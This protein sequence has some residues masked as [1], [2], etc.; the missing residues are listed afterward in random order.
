M[1]PGDPQQLLT[2]LFKED[3]R[4]WGV[5]LRWGCA[6]ASCS[7]PCTSLHPLAHLGCRRGH[8]RRDGSFWQMPAECLLSSSFC[9]QA[10]TPPL[11]EMCLPSEPGHR[12]EGGALPYL[13]PSFLHSWPSLVAQLV[14]SLP[15]MRESWV[16]PLGWEDP[17]E[18]ERAT[19]S[20][21]LA[22][23][24]P[25]TEEP[26]GLQFMGLQSQTR[27]KQPSRHACMFKHVIKII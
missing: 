6:E 3:G 4:K 26:G 19:H 11:T 10:A 13:V 7:Q 21:I 20:S 8:P 16:Q 2:G 18:K 25:W 15:A 12:A 14:E 9:C 23:R 24:I 27:V 5:R 17:L 1:A 22:R